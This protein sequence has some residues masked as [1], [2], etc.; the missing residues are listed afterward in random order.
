MYLKFANQKYG[1]LKL[2][3]FHDFRIVVNKF[4]TTPLNSGALSSF[5]LKFLQ[6]ISQSK[7]HLP[8]WRI[9]SS[10]IYNTSGFY[11]IGV[12]RIIGCS[13]ISLKTTKIQQLHFVKVCKRSN[14]PFFIY[15]VGKVEDIRS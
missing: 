11:R 13:A 15:Q 9:Q 10:I 8:S 6:A 12:K 4:L 1:I 5:K 7:L 14:A 3:L 2:F